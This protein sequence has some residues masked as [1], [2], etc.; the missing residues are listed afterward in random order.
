MIS[1]IFGYLFSALIG[2]SLGLIG[3]GGS[4]LTV[5]ILVYLFHIN[6]VQATSY[7]LFVVGV[8][9][10]TGAWSKFR[11][12]LID[13][14]T[15]VSF[16]APSIT[17][18]FI[19]RHFV[20]PAIPNTILSTGIFTLT[21][22]QFL[23]LLFA[24]L[25]IGASASMI[26]AGRKA[27]ADTIVENKQVNYPLLMLDG[28]G[29]GFLTG[30]VG[31]GGGFLII[32]ALVFLCGLEMKSAIGTSLAIIAANSLF[33]FLGDLSH[34]SPD[35]TLLLSITVIAIAGIFIGSRLNKK[36]DGQKLKRGFG[37]FVLTVGA[38]ILIREL[39]FSTHA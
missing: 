13:L 7:S 8:T 36:I 39:F 2:V 26:R 18:I 15:V 23:L 16:G 35:W 12:G 3:G 28:L 29:V 24:M 22:P 4:I 21:K 32:P 27:V 20:L 38:Y 14:K 34:Y 9:S 33:G 11:E 19:T 5:P 37:W 30:C 25:M 17:A 6:P 31:A 1:Q 10:L